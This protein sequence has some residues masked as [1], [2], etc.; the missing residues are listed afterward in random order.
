M[1]TDNSQQTI[2]KF[3][4]ADEAAVVDVWHRSGGYVYLPP[5]VAG[6]HP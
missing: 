3:Q 2:R 6:F 1:R 5:D 4:H